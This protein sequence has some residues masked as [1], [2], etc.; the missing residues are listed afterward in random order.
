MQVMD[1]ESYIQEINNEF[2]TGHA[3][4]HA[5]RPALKKLMDS[6]GG[7]Q[8]VNDPKQS[9]H[10]NPDFVL[11]SDKDKD[12]ILG[13]AE[14]KDLGL[15]L[16]KEESSDQMRRYAGY[17]NLYLTN[18]VE[19]R[20]FKNG[21]KYQTIEIGRIVAGRLQCVP[22]NY[23]RLLN[24]L[25]AFSEQPPERIRSGKRL[26]QIMGGKA[27]RIR[28]DVL[29][30]VQQR[31][32]ARNKGLVRIYNMMKK[33][34]VHDL[35]EGEFANMYAQT[36]VYGLFIA[37]YNDD[38]PEDFSRQEARDLIPKSNPFLRR[39][40]D[41][42]VGL[43]FD[44]RLVYVVDELCDV[45]AASDVKR[46]VHK[47]LKIS[48]QPEND[49]DPAIYFYEDFLQEYDPRLR[50]K[51]GVY[52]TPV[53]IVKFMIREVDKILKQEFKLSRG[54]ADSSKY[55]AANEYAT[56]HRVQILD[57]AVGTATF[58]NETIKYI[59]CK[60]FKG[61]EGRWPAYATQDLLPRLHG[62]ELMM[63]P[64]I[65]AHLKLSMTLEETGVRNLNERLG[66]Y[67][68]NSLEAG[69][70]IQQSLLDF[71]LANAVN[72]EGRI[73]AEI[74]SQRPV[75]IIVGNPPYAGISSNETPY[76]N[77]FS[78][79]YRVEPGGQPLK[80]RTSKW[81]NDDYVKFI[82]FGEELIKRNGWGVLA[83]ITNHGFLDNPTFRGM[84]WSLRSTFNKIYILD[85]HGNVK[86]RETAPDGSKD[87]NVFDIQQGVS[88]IIAV[89]T[90]QNSTLGKVFHAD[91][92][93]TKQNKFKALNNSN[94]KFRRI[95][96]DS[97]MHYFQQIDSRMQKQYMSYKSIV[98]IFKIYGAGVST[99]H[100]EFVIHPNA[101]SLLDRFSDFQSSAADED[102]LHSKFNVR[103]KRGW[104]ILRGHENLQGIDDISKFIQPI[105]YRPFDTR[106]I[107]LEDKLVWR[108]VQ[109]ISNHYTALPDNLGM[110]FTRMTKGK[111]FAHAFV[112]QNMNEVI[113]LSPLTGTNAFNAPL[114]LYNS[115]APESR[116]SNI[117]ENTLKHFRLIK[118]DVLAEEI[119][120]Y[121]YAVLHSVGYRKRY[122]D[123]LKNDFPRIP[124]P[125]EKK[126]FLQLRDLGGKLRNLHLMK[127]GELKIM[128]T[129]PI[130]GSNIVE[131]LEYKQD[132]VWVNAEQ[133]FGR[134][135][136]NMWDFF[137]GG[138]QPAQK[139]LKDRKG[140][141]LRN[142]DIE[143]YQRIIATIVETGRLMERINAAWQF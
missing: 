26:A 45:F 62:F 100:D 102:E 19:F 94:M 134:V 66:I 126:I 139:W 3:Q 35:S 29:L 137:V 81:L 28:D 133:Y 13:Y 114:Y 136:Q 58:L 130:V 12:I 122:Q 68:T 5:Y 22:E 49:K 103:K 10:G 23:D 135:P 82:S 75:M 142:E 143:Y 91:L 11:L 88:I 4:E 32:D 67:L 53:P 128:T 43:D 69:I 98:D 76:A 55:N 59:H 96:P 25:K 42:I 140:K 105:A 77:R 34:L 106:Y 84:R 40:F 21:E 104:D 47:H 7:V 83:M 27:R 117:N 14:A 121:I 46:I 120:D 60:Y 113:F 20:F 78:S 39:F 1:I 64:Y 54:I 24:E 99:A 30:F 17:D 141:T 50:K 90:K 15:N 16:D 70:P 119:F 72:E 95:E 71:G 18:Y 125:K 65:I 116:E 52:Y 89:K 86:K 129:F 101:H 85:L 51:M 6:I 138:Y 93:G 127:E 44:R 123:F 9:A 63:A 87:E 97:K 124:M 115:L 61:Q 33:M 107:F 48:E 111:D 110:L 31:N 79:K 36:L 56:Q 38:T 112:V 131:K 73:S 37:R 109:K 92:Y 57:P 80:E 2:Q 118:E 8:A 132:C 74:K 108:P 41:H